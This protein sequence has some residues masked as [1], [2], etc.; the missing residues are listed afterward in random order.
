VIRGLVAATFLLV[1]LLAACQPAPALSP[2]EGSPPA[3]LRSPVAGSLPKKVETAAGTLLPLLAD[4]VPLVRITSADALDTVLVH[5]QQ[6]GWPDL[7][8]AWK[9]GGCAFVAWRV[10]HPMSMAPDPPAPSPV[11][12]IR[13][14]GEVDPS[15]E[16]WV[17]VDATTGEEGPAF[18]GP[19]MADCA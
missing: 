7:D 4:Q 17:M 13:L 1:E 11:D 16:T 9:S 18:G 14:V 6:T 19:S 12:V 3:V 2:N 15:Q 10:Q 5:E 8:I